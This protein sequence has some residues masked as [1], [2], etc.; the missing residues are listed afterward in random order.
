MSN[1]EAKFCYASL[2]S[3]PVLVARTGTPWEAPT[4]PEAHHK[5]KEPRVVGDHKINGVWEDGLAPDLH[6]IL[7]RKR[8]D[9]ASTDV[10]HI[11][12]AGEPSSEVIV[13]I[14]VKPNSLSCEAGIDA[15]VQCKR[16]LI[17]YGIEGV[18]VEICESEVIRSAGP[19]PKSDSDATAAVS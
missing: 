2:P 15:A 19:Q 12:Y 11:G 17:L 9:W 10:V 14:G 16:L 3:G 8:A 7:R 4:G 13:W 5:L 1:E 18:E 6:A